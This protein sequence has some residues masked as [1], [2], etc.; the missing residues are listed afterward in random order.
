MVPITLRALLLTCKIRFLASSLSFF[1]SVLSPL[2]FIAV[3]LALLCSLYNHTHSHL[4]TFAFAVNF[5]ENTTRNTC[6]HSC[7]IFST[8]TFSKEPSLIIQTRWAWLISNLLS[9][10]IF[11]LWI[12]FL[13][14]TFLLLT[15]S[16]CLFIYILFSR[17]N[18][19][20]WH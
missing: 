3:I 4:R 19:C 15:L 16:I 20:Q 13:Y 9:F 1:P 17:G 7:L 10:F 12:I 11:L 14:N 18:N 8:A 6:S 2:I 5:T